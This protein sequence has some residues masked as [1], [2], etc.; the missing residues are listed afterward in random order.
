MRCNRAHYDVTVMI[1]GSLNSL[2][3]VRIGT[4]SYHNVTNKTYLFAEI[5]FPK[6]RKALDIFLKN[7]H[8]LENSTVPHVDIQLRR[9][10]SKSHQ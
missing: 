10:E 3:T 2:G 1:T 6:E 9:S 8:G 4:V 5:V 7:K